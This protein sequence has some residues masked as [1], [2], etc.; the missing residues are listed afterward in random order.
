MLGPEPESAK[1]KTGVDSWEIFRK[2]ICMF[3]GLPMRG[4]THSFM[5]PSTALIAAVNG[6]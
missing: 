4:I 2:F 5:S 6:T 3:L 1:S